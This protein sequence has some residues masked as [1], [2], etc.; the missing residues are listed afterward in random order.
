LRKTFTSLEDLEIFYHIVNAGSLSGAG[1]EL[2]LSPAVVCRRLRNLET[3]LGV[4]LL[5]RTTRRVARTE[6]G[7][8]FY[9][10]VASVLAALEE[11][12]TFIRGC[13][14][15]PSGVLKVSVPTTFGRL[16]VA[17][18]LKPF[19]DRYPG[20]ALEISLTDGF[21][22][23]IAEGF[24][25]AIRISTLSDC[26]LVARRLC[27]NHRVICAAPAYLKK[28]GIP[29]TLDDLKKHKLLSNYPI[30]CLEGPEGAV[31][32]RPKSFITTNSSDLVREETLAGIG[33][34]LRS[35]WDVGPALK[36]G[37]LRRILTQY[38]GSPETSIYAVYPS[39]RQVPAK[40]R[41]FV[42]HFAHIYGPQPYWDK[43]LAL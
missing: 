21:T 41:A 38:C 29:K 13:S 26:P 25:L 30:W 34:A 2:G 32:Y 42:S 17:P 40:V 4:R 7:T 27:P 8:G 35:T 36:A 39:S 1:R 14:G 43:G 11:A 23:V 18:H 10:H 33:I 9:Q 22:D 31:T 5:Q 24:D 6:I 28:H 20:I 3:R 37:T 19:L 16:H 15:K 12:E